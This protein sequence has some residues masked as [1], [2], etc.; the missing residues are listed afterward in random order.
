MDE[1]EKYRKNLEPILFVKQCDEIKKTK[2]LA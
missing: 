1:A 2:A